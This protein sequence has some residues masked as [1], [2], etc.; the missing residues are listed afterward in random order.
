MILERFSDAFD[1]H[2]TYNNFRKRYVMFE[3]DEFV[4]LG[5]SN[6]SI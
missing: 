5:F 1:S 4:I 3:V 2:L 6:T